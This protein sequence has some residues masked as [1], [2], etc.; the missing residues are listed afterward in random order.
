[1][2][3]DR[4]PPAWVPPRWSDGPTHGFWLW[5]ATLGGIALWMIHL[6]ALAAL[7]DLACEHPATEWVMHGL[8]VGLAGASLAAAWMSWALVRGRRSHASD[9][10]DLDGRL[11]FMGLFGLLVALNSVALI[12]WEGLYVPVIDACR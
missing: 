11:R 8:T 2:T 12:V 9:R 7:A 10:G 1:M 6:V 5:Y 4:Q 3:A